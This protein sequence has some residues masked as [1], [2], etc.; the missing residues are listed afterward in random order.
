VPILDVGDGDLLGKRSGHFAGLQ[1]IGESYNSIRI[2]IRQRLQQHGVHNA[3]DRGIGPDAESHDQN[4]ERG[5]A[6]IPTQ[7][8]D[9]VL[10][11]AQLPQSTKG[12]CTLA[13]DGVGDLGRELLHRAF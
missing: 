5:K 7:I 12:R 3:G 1:E 10:Q 11:I 4:S 6:W 8:A 9:G 2:A 13:R